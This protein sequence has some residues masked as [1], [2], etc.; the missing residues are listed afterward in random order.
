MSVDPQMGVGFLIP[1]FLATLDILAVPSH[2]M[3][4]GPIVVLEAQA[5]GVPVMGADLGGIAE[6]VRDGIDGWLLPFDAPRAW[7]AAIRNAAANPGEVALRAANS[8]RT[9][10]T[11]DIAVEMSALYGALQDGA[12]QGEADK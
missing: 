3:E 11:R 6:R 4:T 8:V 9:R 5:M 1:A 2:W 10:T 12:L 7:A